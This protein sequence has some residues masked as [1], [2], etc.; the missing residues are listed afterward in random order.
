M[1][2]V[3]ARKTLVKRSH[4]VIR[5]AADIHCQYPPCQMGEYSPILSL[6]QELAIGAERYITAAAVTSPASHHNV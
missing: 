1:F 6:A 3:V 2:G 5:Q 4:R